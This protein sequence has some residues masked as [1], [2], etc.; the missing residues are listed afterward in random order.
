M[1]STPDTLRLLNE[2]FAESPEFAWLPGR[3]LWVADASAARAILTNSHDLYVEHSDFFHLRKGIFGPRSSQLEIGR[4]ARAM[5]RSYLEQRS[6]TIPNLVRSQITHASRWPD[7]G[8]LLMLEYMRDILIAPD[9]PP[10]LRSLV[11]EIV[12]RSVIAGARERYSLLHRFLFRKRAIRT[13]G[14]AIEQRRVRREREPRDILDAIVRAGDLNKPAHEL[15]QVFVSFIFAVTGSIGFTL[16]WTIY[17]SGTN[18]VEASVEPGWLVRES[19]RLWPI[20]WMLTRR[21]AVTHEILGQRVTPQD[22]IVVSPYLTHR[23]EKHWHDARNFC[24]QRWKTSGDRHAYIPFGAGPHAC[25][26]ISLT[27]QVVEQFLSHLF[28]AYHLS[29]IAEQ[30]LPQVSSSLAPPP[31]HLTLSPSMC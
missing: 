22:E 21:A 13:L 16:G 3:Q 20:A 7:A 6:P 11:D 19:L 4:T 26:A 24:P 18:K 5:L 30:H 12:R 27:F 31:F 9:E 25:I 29:V 1:G 8:N 10:Q 17:L 15:A 28:D 2:A 23:R 14:S